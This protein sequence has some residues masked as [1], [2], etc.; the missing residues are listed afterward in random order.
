MTALLAA[1]LLAAAAA[2]A[3][4]VFRAEV[5]VVRVEVLVTRGGSPVRGL[6][7]ADFELRDEGLLQDLEPI[8]EEQT[9]VDAV[10]V[11]DASG[12]VSGPKL[13]SL[14][15]AAGA[16]L[17][18]LRSGE[19]AALLAFNQ[20]VQLL[21]PLTTDLAAVRRAL[22]R[23]SPGGTRRSSTRSTRRSGSASSAT[24]APPSWCSA[25]ASTT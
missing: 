16:F 3:P 25:T 20:E 1:T 18:G 7:A 24:A 23:V 4:P 9:P 13:D 11:L 17:D 2:Q 12:S 5:G 15:A 6:A 10:L 8:L 14:R 21:Q 22:D 19:Q